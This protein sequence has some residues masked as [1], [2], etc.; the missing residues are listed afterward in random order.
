MHDCVQVC[1]YVYK[2]AHV[3]VEVFTGLT[4]VCNCVRVCTLCTT[5][6]LWHKHDIMCA[7]VCLGVHLCSCM[8]AYVHVCACM[9]LNL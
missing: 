7:H 4:R 2:H 1:T 6:Y 8:C 5:V 9:C 3:Y